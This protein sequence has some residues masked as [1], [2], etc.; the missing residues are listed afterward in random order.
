MTPHNSNQDSQIINIVQN[1]GI[2]TCRDGSLTQQVTAVASVPD[3]FPV[4]VIHVTDTVLLNLQY[5]LIVQSIKGT[6]L[7]LR[8]AF[9]GGPTMNNLP[10]SGVWI[11]F[12]SIWIDLDSLD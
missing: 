1:L 8:T 6:A 7:T 12:G 10:K 9:Y 2:K 3:N 11:S 5:Y 4:W